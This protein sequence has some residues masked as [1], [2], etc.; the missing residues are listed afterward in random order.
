MKSFSVLASSLALVLF[1]ATCKPG[2]T[3]Q[4][5]ELIEDSIYKY[6]TCEIAAAELIIEVK[7]SRPNRA[8]PI[9]HTFEFKRQPDATRRGIDWANA[10]WAACGGKDGHGGYV[11]INSADGNS[12][13]DVTVSIYWSNGGV[14]GEAEG[15]L[16]V[17]WFGE[18]QCEIGNGVTVQ[19]RIFEV[20]Q[21]RDDS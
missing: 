1:V 8:S 13:L 11:S 6:E 16:Q 18:A 19:T 3:A 17:P 5:Y 20:N 4:I 21:K 14:E 7:I 2:R 15:T 12:A 10:H 9:V